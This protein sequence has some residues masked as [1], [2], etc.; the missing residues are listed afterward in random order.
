MKELAV[1]IL[2]AAALWACNATPSGPTMELVTDALPEIEDLLKELDLSHLAEKFYAAGFTESRYIMR[3]KKMD[4]RM[5]SIEWGVDREAIQ[6]VRKSGAR[7][8]LFSA[9]LLSLRVCCDRCGCA[10]LILGSI[11]PL[12]ARLVSGLWQIVLS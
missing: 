7:D 2:G 1:V 4:L 5:M 11:N 12:Q 6:K 9:Y 8:H 10:S 3:M